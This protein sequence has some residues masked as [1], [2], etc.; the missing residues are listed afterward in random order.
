MKYLRAIKQHFIFVNRSK[1]HSFAQGFA[2]GYMIY[3]LFGGE[4]AIALL[5]FIWCYGPNILLYFI[6]EHFHRR[7]KK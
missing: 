4:K 6:I 3:S 5:M 1:S 7:H 2:I